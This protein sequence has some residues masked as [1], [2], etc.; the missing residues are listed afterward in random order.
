MLSGLRCLGERA[1]ALLTT[2]WKALDRINLCPKR[3]GS[4]VKA[5][6]VLTQFEHAGRY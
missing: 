5:A 3:I 1:A 6:L 4:I 2:R